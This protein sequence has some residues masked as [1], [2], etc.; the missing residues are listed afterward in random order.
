MIIFGIL[1]FPIQT[2]AFSESTTHPA[3]TEQMVEMYNLVYP[4]DPISDAD[5]ALMIQGSI[6]E[7]TPPRWINHF[8]DPTTG[9]GWQGEKAGWV[10]GFLMRAFSKKAFSPETAVSSKQWSQDRYLQSRNALVKG[11]RTWQRALEEMQV[12]HNPREAYYTLGFILHLLEDATVP[13]H[14]R[15]D[16]HAH[17]FES[18]T[19]DYGSPYE[20]YAKRQFSPQTLRGKAQQLFSSG[21]RPKVLTTL[22]EHF[23]QLATYSNNFFFSKDTIYSDKY[24]LPL[25]INEDDAFGYG[26]DQEKG[27]PNFPL[28]GVENTKTEN[29]ITIKT[30]KLGPDENYYPIFEAY[31]TRHSREAI[32]HGSGLIKLFKDTVRPDAQSGVID[33]SKPLF[34]IPALSPTILYSAVKNLLT[35]FTPTTGTIS[36][37]V[38][39]TRFENVLLQPIGAPI[40][41]AAASGFL[42]SIS[43]GASGSGLPGASLFLN[44]TDP[45]K[46]T[47]GTQINQAGS[48]SLISSAAPGGLQ[49]S[50]SPQTPALPSG[51]TAGLI[52]L[53][54][55]A[56]ALLL[57]QRSGTLAASGNPPVVAPPPLPSGLYRYAP[58]QYGMV[59]GG[60]W[61]NITDDVRVESVFGSGIEGA[62]YGSHSAGWDPAHGGGTV[63]GPM[64]FTDLWAMQ[65]GVMHG[66]L[67]PTPEL[68]AQGF[69]SQYGKGSTEQNAEIAAFNRGVVKYHYQDLQSPSPAPVSSSPSTVPSQYYWPVHFRPN[70]SDA[71][72]QSITHMLDTRMN[73]GKTLNET[74]ARNYAYAINQSDWRQYLG[75]RPVELWG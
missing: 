68:Y 15:N 12:N 9:K 49:P 50:A 24:D 75:K 30:Y 3:L 72:K 6:D 20:E 62:E 22:N 32:L 67:A 25:V 55:G 19:G 54:I 59:V 34:V 38:P 46:L 4:N 56:A 70:L 42:G 41:G 27:K 10:P 60:V 71:Q 53:A 8:Y 69:T 29:K 36:T 23:D 7:D 73:E 13:D 44:E 17:P 35:Y 74:D 57:A 43:G 52:G 5:K 51:A 40:Q 18:V 45:K 33:N 11:D 31:F 61:H 28:V 21:Y 2:L 48:V 47:L 37:I 14:A 1:F 58:G 63:G 39:S 16:T 26:R 65:P 66:G 64:S